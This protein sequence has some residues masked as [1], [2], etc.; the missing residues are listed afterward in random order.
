MK[1][2]FLI[3][4]PGAFL[5]AAVLLTWLACM[6][7]APAQQGFDAASVRSF[8][9]K[10][11]VKVPESET[12]T[13]MD[14]L[15][16][17]ALGRDVGEF[18]DGAV[19]SASVAALGKLPRVRPGVFREF[20]NGEISRRFPPIWPYVFAGSF[21]VLGEA[22]GDDPVV[23]FFNPFFDVA[24]LTRWR[25]MDEAE[26]GASAGFHMIEAAPMTGTAFLADRKSKDSDQP[27]WANSEGL[28]EVMLV[29]SARNF[30]NQ[31]EKRYP[32]FG[33]ATKGISNEE[34]GPDAVAII[35]K[36]VF[37]LLK[38]VIDAQNPTAP[39]NYAAGLKELRAALSAPSQGRLE[40]WLPPGNPQGAEIFFRL[41]PALRGGIKPYLVVDELV[42][43]IDPLR[44]PIGFVAVRFQPTAA[45]WVPKVVG[46]FNLEAEYPDK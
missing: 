23:A 32:P 45:G 27:H 19:L 10:K 14:D 9:E 39:R 15:Q 44:L 20:E 16:V 24:I 4:H 25:F 26:S 7:R 17:L 21:I 37:A 36:R 43:L 41:D 12:V 11:M 18:R 1:A 3:R 5:V 31:F 35:E 46:L 38:W 8:L 13:E 34:G 22:L 40:G 28:F 2:A 30:V 6:G 42:I 29:K 33:H